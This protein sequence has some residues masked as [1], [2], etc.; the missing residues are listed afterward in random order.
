MKFPSRPA[1]VGYEPEIWA[2]HVEW[3]LSPEI[4]KSAIRDRAHGTSILP[5]W[6]LVLEYEYILRKKAMKLLNDH[7]ALTLGEALKRAKEDDRLFQKHF[8][9]PAGQEASI[10]ASQSARQQQAQ[11]SSSRAGA[12]GAPFPPQRPPGA[13][14]VKKSRKRKKGAAPKAAALPRK[15]GKGG[16]KSAGKR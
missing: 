13:A 8:I 4:A 2:R 11:S 5:S 12:S 15:G 6:E 10:V 7:P 14:G 9:T 3:L 1:L 16:G